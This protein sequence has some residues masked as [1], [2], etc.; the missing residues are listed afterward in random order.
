LPN[1]VHRAQ[2]INFT[3]NCVVVVTCVGLILYNRRENRL[4]ERGGRDYRLEGLSEDEQ[5]KLGR[6]HPRFR[7]VGVRP[8]ATASR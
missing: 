1:D 3:F 2:A 6:F 5:A 7:C 4:R 8:V